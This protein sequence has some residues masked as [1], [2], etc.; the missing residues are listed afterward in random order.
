MSIRAVQ[1]YLEQHGARVARG[2]VA[3]WLRD[4]ECDRCQAADG[5]DPAG[6]PITPEPCGDERDA[7]AL[8][9][10]AARLGEPL[11]PRA[12]IRGEVE[13]GG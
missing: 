10:L 9:E 11:P 7:G 6:E 4:F 5:G 13:A 12:V 3:N 1:R 2:T 8:A